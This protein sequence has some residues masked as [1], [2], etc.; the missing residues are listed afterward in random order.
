[1]R[2]LRVKRHM[3]RISGEVEAVY[4]RSPRNRASV[5]K[6]SGYMTSWILLSLRPSRCTADKN[7]RGVMAGI[8]VWSG[9]SRL[10]PW[11]NYWNAALVIWNLVLIFLRLS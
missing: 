11:I 9:H 8:C 2:L 10:I 3:A 4:S 5:I 7:L 6:P 1:M